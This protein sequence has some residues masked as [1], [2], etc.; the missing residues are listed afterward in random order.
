MFLR[1][2]KLSK[3]LFL[4]NLYTKTLDKE[5]IEKLLKFNLLVYT[6]IIT[7]KNKTLQ[8]LINAKKTIAKKI[9]IVRKKYIKLT[10]KKN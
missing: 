3:K 7:K 8:R 10:F 9:N 1:N 5:L 4:L 6:K 2:I